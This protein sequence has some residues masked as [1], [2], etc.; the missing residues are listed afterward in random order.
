MSKATMTLC[1]AEISIESGLTK[2]SDLYKIAGVSPKEKCLY[3]DRD[4]DI[5]IPL[6][7]NDHIIVRGGER[8]FAGTYD[9]QI[10]ENPAVRRPI[11][12]MFNDGKLEQGLTNA[13]I[14]GME[15]QR[16]D[17][18]LDSSKLFADL[19]GKVDA[20]IAGD[21]T[22]VVQDTDCYFTIPA[23][24]DDS[25]DLEECA[26]ND[27]KPPKGQPSYKIKI[28]GDKYKVAN[29]MIIG[30][31]ILNLAGK[32]YDEWTMHRKFRGGRRKPIEKD[33]EV[34]VSEPGVE[35]F[36]TARKQAQQGW[37]CR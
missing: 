37:R 30:E 15:L 20:F 29:Q 23:G 16:L 34:D 17:Q 1:D 7:P 36:E 10:G 5:D 31:A 8:I 26:K 25:V 28:D 35:R 13:K 21:I 4:K 33:E 9:P 24:D 11:T 27:R 3:L 19:G 18:N 32:S 6:L 2:A 14:T 12:P 22:L